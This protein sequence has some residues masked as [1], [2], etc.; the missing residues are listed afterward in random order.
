MDDVINISGH[1]LGTAEIEDA[2]V[3]QAAFPAARLLKLGESASRARRL[4]SCVICSFCSAQAAHPA[5][6]ETAVIGYPHDIKGEGELPARNSHSWSHGCLRRSTRGRV[7]GSSWPSCW[8]SSQVEIL[9][10]DA[11]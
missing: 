4:D 6:P 1:R 3:R 11:A 5:V 10:E 8:F 2:M 9:G 7:P